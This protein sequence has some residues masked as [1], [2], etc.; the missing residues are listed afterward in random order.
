MSQKAIVDRLRGSFVFEFVA[1]LPCGE[2]GG[3]Q[4]LSMPCMVATH[5]LEV[6]EDSSG[7]KKRRMLN[8]RQG[9]KTCTQEEDEKRFA[10]NT[11]STQ[12]LGRRHASCQLPGTC[13][14]LRTPTPV[15]GR[16][17]MW[18]VLQKLAQGA[19]GPD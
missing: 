17:V 10:K 19:T 16:D 8:N 3:P 14:H 13:K 12:N 9:L 1:T 7:E 2:E 15:S 11:K 5:T 18:L 6:L 4:R